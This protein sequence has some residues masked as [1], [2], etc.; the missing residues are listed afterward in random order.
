[1]LALNRDAEEMMKDTDFSGKTMNEVVDILVEKMIAA[2]YISE[3]ANSILVSVDGDSA[4]KKEIKDA[5]VKQICSSL[6]AKEVK[7]AILSQVV[8]DGA[9]KDYKALAEQYGIS[10]GKAKLISQI[11][12]QNSFVTF[13]QLVGLTINELNLISESGELAL[14]NIES[15]GVASDLN[16]IG[17]EKAEQIAIANAKLEKETVRKFKSSME[18]E[19]GRMVYEV[20]FKT[21]T[22]EYEYE[23]DA[24]TGEILEKEIDDEDEDDGDG[25]PAKEKEILSSANCIGKETAKE[26]ALS[27]AMLDPSAALR[28]YECELG[29]KKG[30]L[31][32][33]VEF[34]TGDC[35]Y[36]YL[37]DAET[38]A[39]LK[40]DKEQKKEKKKD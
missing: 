30:K 5:V 10:A 19:D 16:Y 26:I 39:V 33:E 22:K 14:E 32:Y 2:G 7:G 3:R 8:F 13:D 31:V 6:E 9:Q 40:C 11:T 18:W 23:I 37:I 35:E 27:S 25:K 24:R 34:E 12:S 15:E 20:E 21:L 38:G 1:M 4:A 36:E 29:H 28:D 17:Y